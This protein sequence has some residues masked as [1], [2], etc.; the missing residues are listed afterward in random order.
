[1]RHF[2]IAEQFFAVVL[3]PLAAMLSVQYFIAAL[4]PFIGEGNAG[5]AKLAIW[6]TATALAA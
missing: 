2:T 1:M 5:Y 3:L 6:L 4:V